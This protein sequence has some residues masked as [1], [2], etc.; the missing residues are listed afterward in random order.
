MPIATVAGQTGRFQAEHCTYLSF[1][2]FGYQTLKSGT[3]G[4]ARARAPQIFVDGLHFSKA[5]LPSVVSQLVLPQLAFA[6]FH[7]LNKGRLPHVNNGA[8]LQ[9]FWSQLIRHT[10]LLLA[11]RRFRG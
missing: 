9:M 4:Q 6:I 5:Q 2:Y 3:L 11:L 7:N 8:S 1:A 10:R